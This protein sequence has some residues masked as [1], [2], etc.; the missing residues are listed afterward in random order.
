M[1]KQE[2]GSTKRNWRYDGGQKF[3]L[4]PAMFQNHVL[5]TY[6]F[7]RGGGRTKIFE[8]FQRGKQFFLWAKGAD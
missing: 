6:H 7:L 3:F 4:H 8:R 1:L 2:G 5:G